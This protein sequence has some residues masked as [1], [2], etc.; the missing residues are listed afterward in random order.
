MDQAHRIERRGREGRPLVPGGPPQKPAIRPGPGRPHD[1]VGGPIPRTELPPF[2]AAAD[3][4]ASDFISPDKIVLEAC[5]SCRPVLASHEAFDTLFVGIEPPLAFERDRPETFAGR[6]EDRRTINNW[7]IGGFS[8][9]IVK[10]S[11]VSA[12]ETWTLYGLGE[13]II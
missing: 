12:H 10:G 9:G 3:V 4:V 5:S 7:V 11:L 13:M 1:V 6:I 2:Y 8:M